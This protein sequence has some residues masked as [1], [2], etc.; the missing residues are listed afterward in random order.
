M[1]EQTRKGSAG[2]VSQAD[3][4]TE[5]IEATDAARAGHAPDKA[6]HRAQQGFDKAT[7]GALQESAGRTH[8]DD[9]RFASEQWRTLTWRADD[10][11]RQE[12]SN[13]GLTT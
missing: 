5:S 1:D 13:D 4:E 11:R 8:L 7:P 9:E 12:Q 6:T 10:A 2:D 3:R